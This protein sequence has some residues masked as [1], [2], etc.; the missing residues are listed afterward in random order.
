MLKLKWQLAQW[1]PR[2]FKEPQVLAYERQTISEAKVNSASYSVEAADKHLIEA[3]LKI[4]RF[5]GV[6]FLM[7]Q[8]T[9]N[10]NLDGT[11]TIYCVEVTIN[12]ED[13]LAFLESAKQSPPGLAIY[14]TSVVQTD[15]LI[16][17]SAKLRDWKP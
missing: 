6:Y 8:W 15:P 17:Y 12:G 2:W 13:T 7:S 3:F 9:E 14:Q 1:F 10:E 5:E 11:A 16:I 4:L